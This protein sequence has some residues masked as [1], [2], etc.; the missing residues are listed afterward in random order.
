MVIDLAGPVS[1]CGHDQ[2]ENINSRNREEQI[3]YGSQSRGSA[4]GDC[5]KR[6]RRRRN[7]KTES[8]EKINEHSNMEILKTRIEEK[9]EIEENGNPEDRDRGEQ[10]S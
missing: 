3:S 10:G 5:W 2:T 1:E 4:I 8:Q 6:R 9:T 7:G